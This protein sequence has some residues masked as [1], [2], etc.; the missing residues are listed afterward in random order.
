MIFIM[1]NVSYMRIALQE[2]K[3]AAEEG[4]IPVGAVIVHEGTVIARARNANR[5]SHTD[6]TSP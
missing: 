4:E 2:A 1:T 3:A 5:A 6:A